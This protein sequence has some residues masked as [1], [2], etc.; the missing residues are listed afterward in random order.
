[1]PIGASYR[2]VEKCRQFL[3]ICLDIGWQTSELDAL[4]E[5]WWKHHDDQT[6]GSK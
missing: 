2:A 4:E 3:T 5:L 1:M 6:G